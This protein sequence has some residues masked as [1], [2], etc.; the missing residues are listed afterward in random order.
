MTMALAVLGVVATAL[1]GRRATRATAR[2]AA[3]RPS[4]DRWH[5]PRL[6]AVRRWWLA[7]RD[8]RSDDDDLAGVL[9]EVA[10]GVRSGSS[11]RLACAEAAAGPGAARAELTAVVHRADRGRPLEAALTDWAVDTT[12]PAA[13]LAAG[14]LALAATAGGPQ[15]KAIDGAAATLRDRRSIAGEVRAQS[16]QARLSALVIGLLPV[17]FL[18]WAAATDR[19]TAAFLVA[20]PVGL[21]CLAAG[22]LLEATGALWTRRV[23]RSVAL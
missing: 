11:L 17:A 20:D 12:R 16:A 18:L 3:Q 5:P 10:R 14:S 7:Q 2:A 6:D 15:A 23:V 8:R 13:R 4:G 22:L 21:V 1:V 19:R 9:E